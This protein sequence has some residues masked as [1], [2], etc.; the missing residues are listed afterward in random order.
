[1]QK[2]VEDIIRENDSRLCANNAPFNPITGLGS[3]GDR[4]PIT[5]SD[6]PETL[7]LPKEMMHISFIKML[8]K[9]GSIQKFVEKG[10]NE[11]YSEKTRRKV[12]ERLIRIR[13]I[14]DFPFWA[15][16]TAYI[17]KKGGGGD[18]LFKLNRP[19]RRLIERLEY[20]RISGS[21]IRLILLKARQWGGSTAIQIYMAWLQL[22]HEVGLNSLV[23]A[24]VSSAASKVRGMFTK[25][26][27]KYPTEL[28]YEIGQPYTE[29]ED[30]FVNHE[31]LESTKRI[32]QRS[33]TISI[34]TAEKP[35]NIRGDD[36]SL[37]HCTEVGLWKKTDGKAPEDIVQSATSGVP[38]APLTMIVYESTAKGTG[39]FFHREYEDAKRGISQFE[40]FF[41]AWFDIDLYSLAFNNETERNTFAEQ[42]WKNRNA[43]EAPSKRQESGRYYWWLWERGATLEAIHWYTK[44]RAKY[45]E[46]SKMASEYPSDD[47][48]AFSH[49]GERVFDKY[50]VEAL[51]QSCRA[52]KDTGE[53]QGRDVR[54]EECVRDLSFASDTQGRLSIWAHPEIYEEEH[55]SNRYLVVVDIGGRSERSDY[56]V[57]AVIDRMFM[58]DGGRPSIV[59]QWYGHID[60][61]LLAWKAVQI[62]KYYDNALL[63][64]ES[65]TAD[66][67]D[68]H[69]E[70]DQ[71]TYLLSIIRTVYSNLY[72]RKQSEDE[73]RE[74]AP[75]K[76]GFHV[77][78]HNKP[79][80]ISSLQRAIRD[81]EY[82]ERDE[83]CLDEYLTYERKENG[84]WGA[85]DGKHDDILMTRAIGLHIC[86][87][88]M[89]LPSIVKKSAPIRSAKRA[90]SAASL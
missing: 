72:A 73:I 32:P 21:P 33:C 8:V 86:F 79:T 19:Q 2:E 41:I 84:A 75:L 38:Y 62:A 78:R 23:V 60:M 29:G 12:I 63:V 89:P 55:V 1:M 34:G 87:A 20:M 30:K 10:L 88:E 69:T 80:I 81:A 15:A 11:D 6:F 40:A 70:G 67:R 24:Q 90:I 71:S 39:N 18:I 74:K 47:V 76:Y 58:I 44:E 28:L 13:I 56:S 45:R 77:G 36:Y 27:S 37:V 3:T 9:Y 49:S 59:A 54:G 42:L 51:R 64:I 4:E 82:V 52:P 46:H 65:N 85:I 50:K 35:D 68:G 7:H 14:H 31:G 25:L 57:I 83:N 53:L 22:V 26:I 48:E 43:E 61:D 5:L 66:S 16:L 17:K